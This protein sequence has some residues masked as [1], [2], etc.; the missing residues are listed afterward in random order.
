MHRSTALTTLFGVLLLGVDYTH[1]T[2]FHL[3]EYR[4]PGAN[5]VEQG[6]PIIESKQRV[7]KVYRDIDLEASPFE[8]LGVAFELRTQVHKGK[9]GSA[10]ARLFPQRQ[11]VDF[12]VEWLTLH[13][14]DGR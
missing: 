4:M 8:E 3:A 10:Q 1:N 13:R 11:V 2:S 6:A 14:D 5:I 9:V 7:W 12:A